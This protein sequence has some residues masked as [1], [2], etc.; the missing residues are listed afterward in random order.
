[1]G[2]TPGEGERKSLP[3]D[4]SLLMCEFLQ[5]ATYS[6]QDQ[7]TKQMQEAERF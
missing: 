7:N 2:P 5:P 1:M 3:R 4:F 6:T